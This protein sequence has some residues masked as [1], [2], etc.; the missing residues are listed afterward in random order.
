MLGLGGFGTIGLGLSVKLI[1]QFTVPAQR[2]AN[3]MATLRRGSAMGMTGM[4]GILNSMEAASDAALVAGPIIAG[5]G[6]VITRG[7]QSAVHSAKD[8]QNTM[9]SLQA[10]SG[11]AGFGG[12]TTAEMQMLTGEAKR[13]AQ[14]WGMMPVEVAKGM[15]EMVK[16]GMK[17]KQIPLVL[18]AAVTA[19]LAAGEKL[20]GE[21]GVAAHLVDLLAAWNF[22]ASKASR[23]GDLLSK[24]AI[25]STVSFDGLFESLKYGGDAFRALKVP[26][27]DVLALLGVVGNAGLKHSIAGTG[28]GNLLR[29][30]STAIAGSSPKK[31]EALAK[32]GLKQSDLH[33]T[34]P[35]G[36]A[37]LIAVL[38]VIR[39][40]LKSITDIYQRKNIIQDLFGTRGGR[41]GD[42]VLAK[43]MDVLV[44]GK[45]EDKIGHSV[46]AFR[47]LLKGPSTEDSTMEIARKKMES[48]Q[49]QVNRLKATWEVFK[50][51]V[52]LTLLPVLTKLVQ[53]LTPIAEF[54]VA[55]AKNPVGKVLVFTI[56]AVGILAI[57]LGALVTVVGLLGRGLLA[58]ST[59]SG[60]VL[61]GFRAIINLLLGRGMFAMAVAGGLTGRGLWAAAGRILVGNARYVPG[62][63]GALGRV[64]DTVARPGSPLVTAGPASLFG[65]GL[66]RFATYLSPLVTSLGR[67]LPVVGWAAVIFTVLKVSGI[68]LI[69]IAKLLVN[70]LK[71]IYNGF[72]NLLDFI[73]NPIGTVANWVSGKQGNLRRTYGMGYETMD[74]GARQYRGP[75]MI[76]KTAP[77]NINYDNQMNFLNRGKPGKATS[78]VININFPDIGKSFAY[79]VNNATEQNISAEL[80]LG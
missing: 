62:V 17:A 60:G 50:I 73:T 18:E 72:L 28:A 10:M 24:T 76:D 77:E 55:L 49:N 53:I 58:M 26:I 71:S 6:Y 34:T 9:I 30:L 27:E 15:E 68:K 13:M 3:S 12:M 79:H 2:I 44:D 78:Q 51:E 22:P 37:D 64:I 52:G 5:A 8:F 54:F 33:L 57:A 80:G 40:K 75:G 25:E 66:L 38:D 47:D 56:T 63:G 46:V 31:I 39:T 11:K 21:E 61:S 67:L 70:A 23:M 1:D 74:I 41:F 32:L 69:D 4:T 42:P 35:E 14:T 43:L 59:I 7:I 29:E 45:I 16:A 48:Y 65:R 36:G 19:S 20:G